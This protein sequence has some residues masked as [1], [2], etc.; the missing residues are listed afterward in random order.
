ML[1][2]LN[3]TDRTRALKLGNELPTRQGVPRVTTQRT[4]IGW[5]LPIARDVVVGP[6][7]ATIFE[8]VGSAL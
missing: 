7:E 4:D 2:M 3:F 6:Y 8:S 5:E 1:V